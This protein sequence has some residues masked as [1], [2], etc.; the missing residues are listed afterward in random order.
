MRTPDS[1]IRTV[2]ASGVSV[3]D[4]NGGGNYTVTYVNNTTSTINQ[5][6]LTFVGTIAER[7]YD[8]TTLATLSGDSLTGFIGSQ[9]VTRARAPRT[10]STRTRVRPRA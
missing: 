3:S 7:A 6:P 10:S 2:T 9:T 5:A 1:A 8:G 4:G